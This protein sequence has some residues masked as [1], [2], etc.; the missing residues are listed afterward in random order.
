MRSDPSKPDPSKPDTTAPDPSKPDTTAPDLTKPQKTV[1]PAPRLGTVVITLAGTP[2]GR[3]LIDD[4]VV[5]N[6]VATLT[7]TLPPGDHTVKAMAKGFKPAVAKVRVIA[8][9]TQDVR[10]D[11]Q[12][13]RR[14]VNAVHDPFD[15]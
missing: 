9:R 8:G 6:G 1:K 11:L 5:G 2:R 14:S 15:E 7:H 10:L 4:K 12:Q 3:I 13:Q